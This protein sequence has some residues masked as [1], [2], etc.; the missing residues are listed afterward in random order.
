MIASLI[1][2]MD[3]FPKLLAMH[4]AVKSDPLVVA[5]FAESKN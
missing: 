5:Y 1:R 3:G 2:Y 4:A